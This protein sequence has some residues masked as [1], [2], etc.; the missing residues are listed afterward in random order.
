MLDLIT[1]VCIE[2]ARSLIKAGAD[3]LIIAEPAS[4]LLSR[5]LFEAFS[6]PYLEVLCKELKADVILHICGKAGH[7]LKTS[8][9][10]R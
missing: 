2:Y 5:D 4:S 3:F 7:L 8:P 9:N 10:S 1:D 6:K